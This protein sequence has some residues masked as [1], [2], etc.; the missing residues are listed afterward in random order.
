MGVFKRFR[1][2][3]RANINE[4]ISRAEDPEKMLN[5][6]IMDMNEQLIASKKSV[7]AAIADEK[8]L[9]RQINNNRAM[10]KEWEEKAVL[11]V[12][13][14]KD[15]LAK[16]ALVRQQEYEGY[17]KE[18]EPQWRAQRESVSRLK[19]SLKQLQSKIDEAQRKK[20][21]LIAR[22]R[23]AENQK[24]LQ[25]M[26]GSISDTS[27]F[28]AFDRM[29][30]KVERIEAEADAMTEM[31]AA[32]SEDELEAEFRKLESSEGDADRRLENL[33]RRLRGIDDK[34]E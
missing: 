26:I 17:M 13:A 32:T 2:A 24:K 1:D 21:I 3:L 27:A 18:L 19:E 25:S 22:A 33:K 14:D 30:A 4:M 15:D 28:D 20:N 34:Q 12:R 29:T 9:E 7:A 10:V 6:I 11:A 23:R 8:R 31:A 16:K 5:Q